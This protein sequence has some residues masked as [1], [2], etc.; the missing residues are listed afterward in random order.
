[1]TLIQA[2][3]AATWKER[4]FFLEALCAKDPAMVE[5]ILKRCER[6][7]AH[8]KKEGCEADRDGVGKLDG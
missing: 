4:I 1:M 6:K 3:N 8:D 7:K 2:W 5:R